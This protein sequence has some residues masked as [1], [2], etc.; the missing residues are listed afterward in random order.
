[1][2]T[3]SIEQ[4]APHRVTM[5]TTIVLLFTVFSYCAHAQSD[6]ASIFGQYADTTCFLHCS[7]SHLELMENGRYVF[8]HSNDYRKWK[9]KGTWTYE[10]GTLT[11]FYRNRKRLDDRTIYKVVNT[12]LWTIDEETGEPWDYRS[13][14]KVAE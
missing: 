4:I 5:K 3:K 7:Y 13:L 12:E 1:M 9:R 6:S 2:R 8:R 14:V 11:L 10:D